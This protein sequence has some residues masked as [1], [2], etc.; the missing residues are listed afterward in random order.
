MLGYRPFLMTVPDV[1]N[2]IR[3][4]GLP[5]HSCR[6]RCCGAVPT[7]QIQF[8]FRAKVN[9]VV[10]EV[11]TE[12]SACGSMIVLAL[13]GSI[14]GGVVELLGHR[15]PGAGVRSLV[16]PPPKSS[17]PAANYLAIFHRGCQRSTS[18]PLN[19]FSR[20]SRISRTPLADPSRVKAPRIPTTPTYGTCH[21]VSTTI[22]ARGSTPRELFWVRTAYNR[23]HGLVHQWTLRLNRPGPLRTE[24]PGDPDPDSLGPR[25]RPHGLANTL[26]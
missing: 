16:R 18:R 11:F 3:L 7:P 20:C 12:C 9:Q 24:A 17:K 2:P 6:S 1:V 10:S 23:A 8:Q 26:S 15:F 19:E 21:G 25:L 13:I 14:I 4:K 5:S 22:V